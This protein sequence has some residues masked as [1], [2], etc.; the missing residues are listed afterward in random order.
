MASPE[1]SFRV[2]G[3]AIGKRGLKVT[4]RGAFMPARYREYQREVKACAIEAFGLHLE[5]GGRW[6]VEAPMVLDCTFVFADHRR[7]DLDNLLGG[8]MDSLLSVAY[9]DDSQVV[10]MAA[11]K[12]VLGTEPSVSVRLRLL[13]E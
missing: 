12:F 5:A 11:R 7:R 13:G 2:P 3:L 4:R 8:V 6:D 1:V 10:E 9:R